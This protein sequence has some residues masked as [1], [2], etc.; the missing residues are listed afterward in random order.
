[1]I[2]SRM[3]ID[4]AAREK[5]F[6]RFYRATSE[7]ATMAEGTGLGLSIAKSVVELHGGSI[8]VESEVGIGTTFTFTLP[9]KGPPVIPSLASQPD[10]RIQEPDPSHRSTDRSQE[11]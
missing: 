5:I 10:E 7:T 4:S 2:V 8:G 3:G 11:G 1:M 6:D 9:V